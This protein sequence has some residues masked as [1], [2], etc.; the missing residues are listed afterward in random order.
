M[1]IQEAI[2]QFHT[3][4]K[5]GLKYVQEAQSKGLDPYMPSL[6]N[7]MPDF[8]AA[9]KVDLGVMEI[10][11]DDI[12][13]TL[14]D[15]RK[16]AFAGNFMPILDENTEFGSKWISL[17]GAQ[18]D[19]GI[20]DPI[21]C[22]EYLGYFYVQEGHKRVSVLRSFDALS[23]RAKV[24]RVLPTRRGENDPTADSYAAFLDFY[25][26]TGVYGLH[27]EHPDQWRQLGEYLGLDPNRSWSADDR[28]AFVSL[29]WRLR[30][31]CSAQLLSRM[32]G[33]TRSDV[34]LACLELYPYA[35]F[36]DLP[37]SDLRSRVEG[38]VPDLRF[39]SEGEETVSTEPVIPGKNLVGRILDG[40]APPTLNI[41]FIHANDPK[42]SVWTQGHDEGRVAMEQA[43]GTQVRVRTY[44]VG[45]ED[46]E[47]LMER[48]VAKDG[49]QLLIATAP[50][51]LAPARQI[52]ALH[53]GLK[54][55]VCALSVPYVGVRTY[56]SR[57]HETKFIAGAIAG[58]MCAGNPIGYIARYPILGVPA[59]V[60][61]FALGV[62]MTNP[63]AKVLLDWSC[64]DGDPVQRLWS[65]GAR[66][67]S[68]HPVATTT[69]SN[70]GPGWSTSLYSEDGS[71]LPLTSDMWDW[72]KTYEQIARSV[73]AGA[74]SAE[75]NGETAVSYWWGMS[76]GVID[77]RLAAIIPEGV[78]QLAGILKEG[79][80]SGA[81]N[82][83]QS[84][85]RDQAGELRA[86]RDADFTPEQLMRMNWLCDN[87][88]GRIPRYD[89]L[90]PMSRET[91]RLLALPEDKPAA[92][93][94]SGGAP[95]APRA[96]PPAFP[97]YRR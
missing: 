6:E 38:L 42:T 39:A 92:E 2:A 89:E 94:A 8:S 17:C 13:G 83:F 27:F 34:L 46:A 50:I 58:A 24:T 22:F 15:G 93:A 36:R 14:A 88:V 65:A 44:I 26:Q 23:I 71:H 4:L 49:A 12:V 5:A 37:L 10:P 91:T 70:I 31:A 25:K 64:L 3:A 69:P 35:Q 63:D 30:E 90:M 79:I 54:V 45:E 59:S 16:G 73:L 7:T 72:G 68:G 40:I 33:Q 51:L 28:Q 48:A 74:W 29:L 96:Y 47:T 75:A 67:I 95:K 78:R 82:P 56:Y 52:A 18:L 85:I 41:A 80:R 21:S 53:P 20:T 87:V 84:E 1:S 62:R 97:L 77:I 60:N 66:I 61:A 9:T 11:M 76:S 19:E 55:L 81:M 57:I 86:P 43:L 32:K